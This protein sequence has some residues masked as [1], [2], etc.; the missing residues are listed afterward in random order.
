VQEYLIVPL[1]QHNNHASF[2]IVA[3]GKV[4]CCFLWFRIIG[5]VRESKDMQVG[6]M[7]LVHADK[8]DPSGKL[9][10]T[11]VASIQSGYLSR[12][13]MLDARPTCTISEAV[14]GTW[15]VHN[16]TIIRH[17][18]MRHLHLFHTHFT[19]IGLV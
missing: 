19:I 12:L 18:F 10:D 9:N 16:H 15:P 13:K 17:I 1:H 3:Q 7:D 2:I 5:Y 14:F 6:C 11:N 4:V 8:V